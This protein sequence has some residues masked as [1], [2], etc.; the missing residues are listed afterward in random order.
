MGKYVDIIVSGVYILLSFI[1]FI[2]TWINAK[3]TSDKAKKEELMNKT[4]EEISNLAIEYIKEAET[5]KNYTG[6]EKLNWVKT[7]LMQANQNIYGEDDLTALVNKLVAMTKNVNV[8]QKK[9]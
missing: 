4:Q 5:F 2:A 7:R 6:A 9:T 8:D 1:M 3:R